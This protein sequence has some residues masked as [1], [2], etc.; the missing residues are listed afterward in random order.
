[1]NKHNVLW[2]KYSLLAVWMMVVLWVF[3]HNFP[4]VHLSEILQNGFLLL[5]LLLIFTALGKRIFRLFPIAFSNR[6]EEWSFSFGLGTGIIIFVVIGLAAL[7]ILYEIVVVGLVVLLGFLVYADAKALCLEGYQ[8]VSA[9]TTRTFHWME[10]LCLALMG[11]AGIATFL[12]A[13]TPPFFYDALVYHLAVPQQYLLAHGFRYFPHH[14]FSN[15]WLNLSMLFTVGLSFSGGMLA[16]LLSWTFAPMTVLAVYGVSKARWGHSLAMTASAVTFFVPGILILSI[17]TSVDLAIMFYSFLGFA[18]LL[19][20]FES[21]SAPWFI[22]AGGFCSLAVGT[23][24]TALITTFLPGLIV[25]VGY[26]IFIA[27]RSIGKVILKVALF[28]FIVFCG[29]SPWIIKNLVY[30]GNPMYPYFNA[31]FGQYVPAATEYHYSDFIFQSFSAF[32]SWKDFLIHTVTSPWRVTMTTTRAAGK[33]GV[34]FLLGLPG[35]FLLKKMDTFIRYILV[36]AGCAFGLWVLLLPSRALR[37]VFQIFPLLSIVTAYILWHLPLSPKK[38]AWITVGLGLLLCYHFALFFKET[39]LLQPFAYLL[40]NRTQEQFVVEHGVTYYPAI[41]YSNQ[42]LPGH[43]KILFVGEL[44]SYYCT[45]ET[46]VATDAN[47]DDQEIILQQ[48]ILDSQ[49]V[50]K[51]LQKLHA[52]GISHILMNRAEM[53]RFATSLHRDSYFHFPTELAQKI[54]QQFFSPQYMR[55]LFSEYQVELYEILYPEDMLAAL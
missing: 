5:I 18:A 39:T 52:M 31:L 14:Y 32:G 34:L 37:Y 54:F 26:E 7:H 11:L 33:T 48:L 41:Q 35:L 47:L 46:V 29:V 17:L 3:F 27:R 51:V 10:L 36:I 8:M 13:A 43:S 45:R 22:M 1:M 28:G 15:Y 30:T 12:A 9:L 53:R 16:K 42:K 50:E 20:W 44:R 4:L 38:R 24:Y 23:K 6:A 40:N 19:S 2:M 25:L 55:L 49:H 21:R